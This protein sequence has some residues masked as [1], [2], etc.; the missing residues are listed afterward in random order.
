MIVVG[1][2]VMWTIWIFRNDICFENKKVQDP[3]G[4][5]KMVGYWLNS[6]EILQKEP[7]TQDG[8]GGGGGKCS[9]S[10]VEAVLKVLAVISGC[11][12]V[13]LVHQCVVSPCGLVQESQ[14]PVC[15]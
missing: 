14:W 3:F 13:I 12:P 8:S 9:L 7:A 11:L 1:A 4:L 10:V 2:A 15:N 6:R 5:V